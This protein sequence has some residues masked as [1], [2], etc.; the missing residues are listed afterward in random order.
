MKCIEKI[1]AYIK[2]YIFYDLVVG[3]S[4]KVYT[5]Y[6]ENMNKQMPEYEQQS[7]TLGNGDMNF[8]YPNFSTKEYD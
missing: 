6:I 7:L 8:L 1:D 3:K 2:I 4:L 5:L